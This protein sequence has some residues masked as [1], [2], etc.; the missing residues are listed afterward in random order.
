MPSLKKKKRKNATI[1]HASFWGC[2][3]HCASSRAENFTRVGVKWSTHDRFVLRYATTCSLR[4]YENAWNFFER[5]KTISAKN[6]REREKEKRREKWR[7]WIA[8]GWN[9]LAR[10]VLV[11][12][13]PYI[14]DILNIV[15]SMNDLACKFHFRHV[16]MM[17]A[18]VSRLLS[19]SKRFPFIYFLSSAFHFF[20]SLFF[21][22]WRLIPLIVVLIYR[23]LSVFFSF[24]IKIYLNSSLNTYSECP[25]DCRRSAEG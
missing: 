11:I 14:Y 25:C 1:C 7:S 8:R 17:A 20:F 4:S 13:V 23:S 15:C 22:K 18:H 5:R 24:L 3:Q 10:L 9:R 19:Y 16:S 2:V 21:S 6:C 12:L